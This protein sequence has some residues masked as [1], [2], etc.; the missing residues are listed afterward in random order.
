MS[1]TE[2]NSFV[3]VLRDKCALYE[4]Y[5]LACSKNIYPDGPQL[6][7]IAERLGKSDF[8]GTVREMEEAHHIRR[9]TICGESGDVCGDTVASWKERLPEI[10]NGYAKEDIFNWVFLEILPDKVFGE[11]GKR[12][13]GGKK[14]EHR[15]TVTF[16]VCAAG[17]KE[18]PIVIWTSKRLGVLEV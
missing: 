14:S 3:G 18:V 5:L 17:E 4:W 9:V 11:R 7:E 10:L 16:L 8:K 1:F 6:K 2:E 13:R 12:C 15:V